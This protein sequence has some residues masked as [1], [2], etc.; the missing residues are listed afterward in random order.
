MVTESHLISHDSSRGYNLSESTQDILASYQ[1]RPED[2][3]LEM[4]EEYFPPELREGFFVEAGAAGGEDDSHSLYFELERGWTGLLVEP[5]VTGLEYR[6]RRVSLAS[7]CLATQPRPH[8]A[9]FNWNSTAVL[10]NNGRA[11]AGIVK[12]GRG[13]GRAVLTDVV[14]RRRAPTPSYSSVFLST[15]SSWL[16]ATPQLTGSS[17]TSRGRSTRSS[18]PSPGTRSTSRWSAWKPT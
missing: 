6:N 1:S 3:A 7:T 12:V 10:E 4:A 2:L 13:G 18:R 5:Q 9:H 17:S 8:Y 16:W 14:G 15:L 11:M